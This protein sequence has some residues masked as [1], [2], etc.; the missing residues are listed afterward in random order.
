MLFMMVVVVVVVVARRRII[1]VL[2]L[3]GV[4]ENIQYEEA[5][6]PWQKDEVRTSKVVLIG[7]NLDRAAIEE[8]FKACRS[9]GQRQARTGMGSFFGVAT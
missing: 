5:K 4:H 3:Q 7:R 6:L 9:G 1:A 2:V 8:E